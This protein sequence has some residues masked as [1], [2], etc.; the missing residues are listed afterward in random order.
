MEFAV[1]LA[2]LSDLFS[3]RHRLNGNPRWINVEVRVCQVVYGSRRL[4]NELNEI[5]GSKGK[6][7]HGAG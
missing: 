3:R 2:C 5:G 7:T 6:A 4:F 1:V